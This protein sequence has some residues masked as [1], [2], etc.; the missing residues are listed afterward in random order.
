M[1]PPNV[2]RNSKLP[3]RCIHPAC[4]KALVMNVYHLRW[5]GLRIHRP[6]S[7][8]HPPELADSSISSDIP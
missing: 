8:S 2:Q 1:L 7:S 5:F 6:K 4:M 3:V